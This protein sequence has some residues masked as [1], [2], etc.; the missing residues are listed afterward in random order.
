MSFLGLADLPVELLYEVQLHALSA[1]FPHVSR[2]FYR[3]FKLAP[4]SF[5]A[6][7]IL[8]RAMADD[9]RRIVTRALRYPL[10]TMEVFDALCRHSDFV[11]LYSELPRRLFRFYPK[12]ASEWTEHDHPLPFLNS[13]YNHPSILPHSIR[14]HD[15][16]GL[17]QAAHA[18]F[19]QLIIFILSH[20]GDSVDPGP[21]QA[22]WWA[23]GTG[24]EEVV[25]AV[26]AQYR[27]DVNLRNPTG[28]T[29]LHHA[30][31]ESHHAVVKVLFAEDG[32]DVNLTDRDG[33][34]PLSWAAREG[35]VEM[36]ELLLT[37]DDINVDSENNY[38]RKTP[39]SLAA[40]IGCCAVVEKLLARGAHIN[41]KDRYGRTPLD[42][43][44]RAGH[45]EVVKLLRGQTDHSV[46]R[47]P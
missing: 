12:P 32:I 46:T 13:L 31:M 3:V 26:L 33:A 20:G 5:H 38:F 10:C 17:A 27:V 42:W 2:H 9:P 8:S 44:D 1:S 19:L 11:P 36:V 21:A 34:S 16:Y 39:L 7:Y 14:F 29:A 28:T 4:T 40:S 37:R 35:D 18:G 47:F 23:A 30:T 25:R 43:A 41:A 6:E 15:I 22:L 24:H 45:K